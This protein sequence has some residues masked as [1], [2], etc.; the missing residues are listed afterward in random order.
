MDGRMRVVMFFFFLRV[1]SVLW[2]LR[3]RRSARA[4][5]VCKSRP[6]ALVPYGCSC[7]TGNQAQLTT[8]ALVN[9]VA[10]MTRIAKPPSR[11][12]KVDTQENLGFPWDPRGFTNTQ[13]T[14]VRGDEAVVGCSQKTQSMGSCDVDVLPDNCSSCKQRRRI[15]HKRFVLLDHVDRKEQQRA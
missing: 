7:G 14:E 13:E 9:P 2:L 11:Q 6:T 4:R 12:H 8:V 3:G 5:F 10:Q 1:T 15:R